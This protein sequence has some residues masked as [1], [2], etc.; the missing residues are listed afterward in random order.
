MATTYK[1]TIEVRCWKQH[2]CIGC[3]GAFAY[4]FTRK[5]T[6][7]A[8]TAEAATKAA[9]ASAVNAMNAE[10]DMHPCPSCGLI[11]PDMVGARRARCHR[12]VF[13]SMLVVASGLLILYL[14]D[15]VSVN[16]L[17]WS[18]GA[19]FALAAII[20]WLAELQNL[21]RNP[22]A[23]YEAALQ[24]VERRVLHVRQPGTTDTPAPELCE[25]RWS[26][27][28]WLALISLIA[29]AL[30]AP[31][32]EWLR[33]SHGWPLNSGWFPPVAGPG[34]SAYTYF[35]D[36]ISSVKGYWSAN[37]TVQATRPD[38]GPRF[39][40]TSTTNKS[41]WGSS[42]SLKSSEKDSNSRL[43]AGVTLPN[44]PGLEGKTLN[45]QMDLNVT[46][47]KIAGQGFNVHDA[48]YHHATSLRVASAGAGARYVRTW[49]IGFL[50][51][52][53]CS[54]GFTRYLIRIAKTHQRLALPTEV[55]PVETPPSPEKPAT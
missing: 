4:L 45:L 30:I 55:F 37:S 28:H 21:N 43:W 31:S 26:S 6:G 54:L 10:V 24:K 5:V 32:A 41:S 48:A 38:G 20:Q 36:G 14:T 51:A 7:Q 19:A 2:T 47:P 18:A 40:V 53:A 3:G 44:D 49:W 46:Y 35:P 1:S 33:M 27:T 50:T 34:D 39:N 17:A 52:T 13:W 9:Q 29:A 23:N 15:V 16:V 25:R 8:N 11:Q 42:I 12:W 22:G